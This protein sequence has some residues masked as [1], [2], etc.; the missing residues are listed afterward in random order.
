MLKD[1]K[2]NPHNTQLPVTDVSMEQ[3]RMEKIAIQ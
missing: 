2:L 1:L 3:E